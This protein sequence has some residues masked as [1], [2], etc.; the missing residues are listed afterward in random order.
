MKKYTKI[1]LVLSVFFII[2]T[3]FTSG[4]DFKSKVDINTVH[5]PEEV[6]M[7]YLDLPDKIVSYI[8]SYDWSEEQLP[9]TI[10]LD[11]RIWFEEIYRGYEDQIRGRIVFSTSTGIQYPDKQWRFKYNKG[12]E[13]RHNL[14][15]YSSFL[16]LFDYYLYLII[17]DEMDMLG[18]HLG[19]PFY[20]KAESLCYQAKFSRYQWWWDKRLERVQRLLSDQHKPFRTMLAYF[21]IA[22]YELESGNKIDA[23]KYGIETINL[24]EKVITLSSEKEFCK[25]FLNKYYRDLNKIASIPGGETIK[26]KL[27]ILDTEHTDYYKE[28][29]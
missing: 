2:N 27:I 8:D 9:Y 15:E 1:V 7:N 4:Q 18:E 20:K 10:D 16:S 17:G 19:T 12:D 25:N 21:N 22:L 11:I 13:I 6:R 5:L 24:L 23:L 29:E 26:E 28:N 14:T 3:P